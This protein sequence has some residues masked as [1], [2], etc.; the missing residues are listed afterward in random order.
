MVHVPVFTFSGQKLTS[1]VRLKPWPK[2]SSSC[3]A[4]KFT[5]CHS[6]KSTS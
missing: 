3:P 6:P 2:A 1:W 4:C 5:V